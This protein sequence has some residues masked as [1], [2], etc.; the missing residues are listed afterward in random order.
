MLHNNITVTLFCPSDKA[1]LSLKYPQ[2]P[3]TLLQYHVVPVK[4]KREAL[5]SLPSHSKIDTLLPGHPLVIVN[6]YARR[7]SNR[8][9]SINDV[10][11]TA[12]NLFENERMIVHGMED[13]FDPAVQILKYPWFDRGASVDFLSWMKDHMVFTIKT[14]AQETSHHDLKDS[15]I[16][17]VLSSKGYVAMALVLDKTLKT[18]VPAE[19]IHNTTV[20]IFCP[21]DKAFFSLKYPQPPLTLLQY[22]VVPV[23]LDREDL[24]S[25]LAFESKIDTLLPGHP[26]VITTIPGSKH[27]SINNVKITAWNIYN[28]GHVIVHGIDDFFD[29]A[30]QILIYPWYDGGA[31]KSNSSS[32]MNVLSQEV[33]HDSL[34]WVKSVVL[35]IIVLALIG[36][37]ISIFA[38]IR[39]NH[40]L[41][42][43]FG[44]VS[45]DYSQSRFCFAEDV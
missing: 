44:Y 18:L 9:V 5:E 40:F 31:S 23:K 13:F 25:S 45:I 41:P 1:F 27:A 15:Q 30:F 39:R 17:D 14:A 7:Y 21:S 24:A 19:P 22:H 36:I 3:F 10:K 34:C 37:V 11:I 38:Y 4:L 32:S 26:L 28:D 8:Y 29:P 12:W 43:Y 35:A 33:D 16:A 2:P 42:S 20:T 6:S